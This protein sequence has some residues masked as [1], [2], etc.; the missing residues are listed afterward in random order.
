M[1]SLA[2]WPG[3]HGLVFLTRSAPLA[4]NEVVVALLGQPGGPRALRRFTWLLAASVMALLALLALTPLGRLWFGGVTGLEPHLVELSSTALVFALLMPGYT[5]LQS[6]FTGA[7]VH[8]G[9][10]RAI[11][12]AVALYL[13]VSTVLLVVG[14]RLQ[15]F[16]G[17]YFALVAFTSGGVLQT[18][19]LWHRSRAAVAAIAP[20]PR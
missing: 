19:W 16:T 14:V 15:L 9:R 2:A 12:E 1:L 20:P 13:V 3:V 11:T 18:L 5:A 8:S 4:F 6:W 7:L 17:I 10:T